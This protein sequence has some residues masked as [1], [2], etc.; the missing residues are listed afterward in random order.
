[1]FI[2]VKYGNNEIFLCNLSCV[3]VNFLINIKWWVGYGNFNVMV[4][5]FDEIGENLNLIIFFR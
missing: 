4:D 1:M 2:L 5:L 3:V